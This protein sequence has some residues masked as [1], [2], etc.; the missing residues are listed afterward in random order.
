MHLVFHLEKFWDP[1]QLRKRWIGS[2]YSTFSPPFRFPFAGRF[3]QTGQHA[4]SGPRN[5]G[6]AQRGLPSFPS[7]LLFKLSTLSTLWTPPHL[8]SKATKTFR[9]RGVAEAYDQ[10]DRL[11]LSAPSI[12]LNTWRR[13][14]WVQWHFPRPTVSRTPVAPRRKSFYQQTVPRCFPYP[15]QIQI[16][17]RN[18]RE[19]KRRE[20]TDTGD[21]RS[22]LLLFLSRF[23]RVPALHTVQG[24][25]M[26]RGNELTGVLGLFAFF[27]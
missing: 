9:L 14:W 10:F 8:G 11:D 2:P 15:I 21:E 13:H 19:R 20:E 4:L 6:G 17:Q 26:S 12:R 16:T 1:C 22:L 25:D 27:C 5:S 23:L 24:W 18:W 7:F 3:A